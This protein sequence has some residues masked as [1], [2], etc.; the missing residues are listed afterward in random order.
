M[1]LTESRAITLGTAAPHF[2][3]PDTV[4]DR[5]VSI[6][7]LADKRGLLVVFMCNHCPY[8]KHLADGLAAFAREYA[9]KGLA[10][11]GINANDVESYPADHPDRMKEEAGRRGYVFP[12]LFDESQE[13]ARAYGAACTPDFFLFDE[14]RRLAYH[15]QFDDSRP[16]NGKPVT[17]RDLRAAADS[18]LAGR[19]PSDN[20]T[21]S[22]GCSIKW[23]R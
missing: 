1:A 2:S 12:Y 16:G 5:T 7:Q 15:G 19:Q 10:V 23:R 13:V 3:L 20:Q 8:V 22:I 14:D 6:D 18:V 11:V 9:G 21:P 4:T 17:G